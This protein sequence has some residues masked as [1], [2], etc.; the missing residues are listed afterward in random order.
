MLDVREISYTYGEDARGI[1]G[2]SFTARSGEV[3]AL[4]GPSG[5][6][7]STALACIAGVLRPSSGAVH[8]R[9]APL[10][11]EDGAGRDMVAFVTQSSSLFER[12]SIW[13]NVALAFGNPRRGTRRQ[14][15]HLLHEL[16]V[17]SLSDERPSKLSLGQRQRAAIATA[18]AQAP[19]VLLADEPTGSLDERNSARVMRLLRRA[20][21]Q[22]AAV[23]L[24]THSRD[25]IDA[26]DAV[27]A[28]SPE[29]QVL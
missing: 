21:G 16:G 11:A 1:N 7:K 29:S 10:V 28:L 22:G 24:A 6:G 27:V 9:D 26:A 17:S 3:T 2:I 8:W 5:T 14:A 18:I 19:D 20:A 4:V 25:V 23:I 15:R 13:E 12:L